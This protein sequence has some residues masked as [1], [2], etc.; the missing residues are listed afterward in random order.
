MLSVDTN[1]V[2]RFLTRDDPDQ[3]PR[4]RDLLTQNDVWLG[5]TVVL[6]T[7]WVLR[8][9]YGFFPT[10]I[11]AAVSALAALPRLEIEQAAAVERALVLYDAGMD[12][13]DALHLATAGHGEA[14]VT[15]DKDC[16]ETA[17]LHGLAIREP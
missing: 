7:E 15:L 16:I 14:F 2:V 17:K 3:S 9:V 5:I 13:A 6:E 4:A 8:S 12:F 1:V 11:S 10:E